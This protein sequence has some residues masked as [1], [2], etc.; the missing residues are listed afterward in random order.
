MPRQYT[1]PVFQAIANRGTGIQ[2]NVIKNKSKGRSFDVI[3]VQI[4]H[5]KNNGEV[6]GISFNATPEEALEIAWGLIKAVHHFL[7]G[8]KP[9]QD[10]RT[11]DNTKFKKS[12]IWWNV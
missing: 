6:G 1:K 12:S 9:Y 4:N 8:F 5:L 11:S 2:V 10:F 7:I 3:G